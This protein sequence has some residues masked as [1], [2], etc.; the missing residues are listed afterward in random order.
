[1][2]FKLGLTGGIGSGKSTVAALL[3]QHGAHIAD[4]DAISRQVSAP[5]G[6]AIA[7]IKRAFGASLIAPDG[8]LDRDA[9]R[10]LIY[11]QPDAK[12]RLEAIIHPLVRQGIEQQVQ[13]AID[14]K[15]RLIVLDIPLLVE[16]A[17][18]RPQLDAVLVVDC[19]PETQIHRVMQRSGLQRAQVQ[20]IIDAQA[21]RALRLAAADVVLCND[22]IDIPTL[23]QQVQQIA[24]RFGL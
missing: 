17:I 21:P 12:A 20:A 3:A 2:T 9:M 24:L 7:L 19:L 4:A 15:H 13:A 22:G 8:S 10:A 18:W 11:T 16:S 1:M 23:S 14:A 6:A 5:G